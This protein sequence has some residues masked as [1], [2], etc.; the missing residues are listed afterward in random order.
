M[1]V[2]FNNMPTSGKYIIWSDRDYMFD[3]HLPDVVFSVSDFP[4]PIK[5]YVCST[6]EESSLYRDYEGNKIALKLFVMNFLLPCHRHCNL[7]H[8]PRC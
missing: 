6:M 4:L 5:G 1:K 8:G 7:K 2:L 3:N